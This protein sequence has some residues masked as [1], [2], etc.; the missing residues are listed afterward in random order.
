MIHQLVSYIITI[1]EEVEGKKCSDLSPA[2]TNTGDGG[3]WP[4]GCTK[5]AAQSSAAA[6]SHIANFTTEPLDFSASRAAY[7]VFEALRPRSRMC[8]APEAAAQL[9]TRLPRAPRPPEMTTDDL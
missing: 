1:H 3:S 5:A 6:R 7:L 4:E 2:W 9:P 8:C